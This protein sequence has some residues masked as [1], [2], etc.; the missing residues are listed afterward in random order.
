MTNPQQTPPPPIRIHSED[1]Y[2][3]A[4]V[5]DSQ[6]RR[7]LLEYLIEWKGYK[8]TAKATSWEPSEHVTN[9]T[10]K[11]TEFHKAYPT[12]PSPL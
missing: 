6:L 3:V 9:A 7:K 2:E 4:K 5:L 12:K 1:E 11:I 10:C 8:G